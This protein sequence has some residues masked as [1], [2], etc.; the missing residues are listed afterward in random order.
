LSAK[1]DGYR[2]VRA[3]P[4]VRSQR[5]AYRAE[6]S[7][8]AR[9]VRKRPGEDEPVTISVAER[10][11]CVV[12]PHHPQGAG[13][14]RSRLAGELA[15][16]V[17]PE[18]LADAVSVAA[19]LVGNA[20]RHADPLPGGVVRVAWKIRYAAG[21]QIVDIRVTDGGG[22]SEPRV[23]QFDPDATDGR[24]LAIVEAL[25]VRWGHE[26]DGLGQT[27]WAELVSTGR[28]GLAAG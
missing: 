15:D 28:L 17:R 18:L 24:G 5:Y 27:V 10:A 1:T 22:P 25:A 12:V 11:W 13:R 20:I 6:T 3:N 19:E 23:R 21:G 9:N 4:A 7:I 14:A 16:L 8:S 26:R 2:Y